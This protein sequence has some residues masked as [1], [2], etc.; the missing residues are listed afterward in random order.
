MKSMAKQKRGQSSAA[1]DDLVGGRIRE[2]RIML[3]L[4]SSN[5]PK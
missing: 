2:R 4:T 1:I 3:G 5:S